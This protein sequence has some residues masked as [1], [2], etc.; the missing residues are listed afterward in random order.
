[1]TP[2]DSGTASKDAKPGVSSD[3]CVTSAGGAG[4]LAEITLDSPD[5]S[6]CEGS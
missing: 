1:M 2:H 5:L 3:A 6:S 4:N